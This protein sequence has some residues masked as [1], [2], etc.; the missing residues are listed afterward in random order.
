MHLTQQNV[1]LPTQNLNKTYC[2]IVE[3]FNGW[4][5]GRKI[6]PETIREYLESDSGQSLSTLSLKKQALK[7]AIRTAMGP[8][9]KLADLAQLDYIFKEI[10]VG[11]IESKIAYS[12]VLSLEEINAL[13]ENCTNRNRLLIQFL[14]DTGVRIA[15]M[16]NS[17]L[18]DC[19][20]ES[21]F[22]FIKIIGK[23]RKERTIFIKRDLFDKIRR[24]FQGEVYLFE[25]ASH[26]KLDPANIWFSIKQVGKSIGRH[27][28]PH[29]FRHSFA[30]HTL[31]VKKKSLKAISNYLG[32]STTAITAD[33]YV[34]DSLMP[35]DLFSGTSI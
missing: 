3:D 22:V 2:R 31:L 6:S 9:A 25:S 15:E 29:M 27:V 17:R 24:E 14:S 18:D 11:R 35:A 21:N 20:V 4:L 16:L 28:H 30:T 23:G 5:A 10:K 8:T 13:I 34:H 12:K 33:M 26:R 19:T 1:E 32:H 7:K